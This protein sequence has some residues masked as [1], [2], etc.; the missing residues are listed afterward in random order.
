SNRYLTFWKHCHRGPTSARGR[1]SQLTDQSIQTTPSILEWLANDDTIGENALLLD[2]NIEVGQEYFSLQVTED[3]IEDFTVFI[4][5]P[6]QKLPRLL[7]N[8]KN[9]CWMEMVPR[10][11]SYLRDAFYYKYYQSNP[12]SRPHGAW[13]YTFNK[14]E[15]L[16]Q[17]RKKNNTEQ[18]GWRIRCFPY[19]FI[20]GFTKSGTSDLYKTL[21]MFPDF[22]SGIKKEPKYWNQERLRPPSQPGDFD[23]MVIWKTPMWHLIKGNEKRNEPRYLTQHHLYSINPQIKIIVLMRNPVDRT[24]SHYKHFN[25]KKNK[26]VQALQFHKDM[27]KALFKLNEC[28]NRRPIRECVHKNW[29]LIGG[30]YHVFIEHWLSVF[31]REQFLFIKSED[32]FNNRTATLLEVFSFLQTDKQGI[33]HLLR[34]VYHLPATHRSIQLTMT[35][36]TRNL[37]DMLP[38]P[39]FSDYLDLYDAASEQIRQDVTVTERGSIHYHPRIIGDFDPMVI[40]KTPMWHLIKGN[41]KRNEPRYLTQHHLYS[42]NPQIKIIVL[43]RNPVDRTYSHYK[44]FNG[45]KNL[46]VQAWQFHKDMIKALF[47]LNQCINRRSIRECVHKNWSLIGGM[48][49]VFIE[50]WLSVF[51]REQFLFI[52]SEDYFNNRT[53][54]LMEVFSFLQTD[55]EGVQHLLRDVYHLPA[56]HRSIQLTM[57]NETRNLLDRFFRPRNM[58]L[59][60]LLNDDRWRWDK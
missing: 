42:I 47:K 31:P 34:D 52:K 49:H 28:I 29:S 22:I 30:M 6:R 53:A 15:E 38:A 58:K 26:T 44:H 48:Y 21:M 20:P 33:E 35:N 8:Y 18:R 36:E 5:Y 23:P 11:F 4:Y 10:Q 1:Q 25:G 13:N 41:E 55:T 32:Y 2:D 56:T 51:P 19:F 17:A 9:P 40:W 59:E 37:L 57:R 16:I 50:H 27:I 7:P 46:N 60:S 24:Y 54:T 14:M 12:K 39:R 43:M 3:D 45:K